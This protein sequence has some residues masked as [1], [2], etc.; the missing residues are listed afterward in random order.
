MKTIARLLSI[1]LI[2]T[3]SLSAYSTISGTITDNYGNAIYYTTVVLF[4]TEDSNIV[5]MVA[6]DMKGNYT[7]EDVA[8]G[9]YFIEANMLS[10]IPAYSKDISFP[11]NNSAMVDLTLSVY[12]VELP[13]IEVITQRPQ[14]SERTNN[15]ELS[16]T[17]DITTCNANLMD[18]M[19]KVFDDILVA[20]NTSMS[21]SK[22]NCHQKEVKVC[23]QK[24]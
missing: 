4:S 23:C 7:F 15:N 8:D 1:L 16:I 6:T 19:K 11:K 12:E 17:E 3:T 13:M 20:E 18:A 14:A 21:T 5:K 22:N 2:S 24:K 9:E 10:H